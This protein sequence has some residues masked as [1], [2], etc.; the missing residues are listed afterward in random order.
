MTFHSQLKI[1][2]TSHALKQGKVIAYPTEAIY[3]LGCDPLNEAAVMHLLSIKQRPVHKGLI[4]IASDFSQLQPFIKPS[5]EMLA[6]IM[7]SWPGPIT[8]IIPAQAWVPAY[9][10]GAHT[11]LAVRVSAH[12]LVQRLCAD[13]AGAIVSTSANISRQTPARSALAVREKF[14]ANNIHILAGATG[15]QQQA[16][17]IYN[18]LDGKCLRIS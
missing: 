11:S 9:L 18:A 14:H 17:A 15:H 1:R 10:S 3:G 4:L 6:R 16:T 12:P 2:M 5:T 7:P 13:F 8:W